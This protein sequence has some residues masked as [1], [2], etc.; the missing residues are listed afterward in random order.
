MSGDSTVTGQSSITMI[1]Q[2][3]ASSHS[4]TCP[5]LCRVTLPEVL[6]SHSEQE[7]KEEEERHLGSSSRSATYWLRVLSLVALFWRAQISHLYNWG[8]ET[9]FGRSPYKLNKVAQVKAST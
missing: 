1:T 2:F 9:S 4:G 7:G 3:T 6:Q 5:L 8:S